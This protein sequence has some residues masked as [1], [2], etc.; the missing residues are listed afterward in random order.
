MAV[1]MAEPANLTSIV[2]RVARLRERVARAAAAVGRS[3]EEI[4]V[5]AVTKGRSLDEIAEARVAGLS[6]F[7]E[8]Y[9]QEARAKRSAALEGAV[10]HFLGRVQRNKL[11][12][13]CASF[14]WLHGVD[15]PALVE[16][17]ARLSD[18]GETLPKLLV[19][20]RFVPGEERPGIS[21][22][23][24]DRFIEEIV[25][26]RQIPVVGLMTMAPPGSSDEARSI[27]RRLRALAERL[28]ARRL[29]GVTMADL[30]MGMSDDFEA[31]I[32]EGATMIRIGRGVFGPYPPNS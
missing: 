13:I 12:R 4:G 31:A 6:H 25:V 3:P 16:A 11:Q 27:F 17:L 5:I 22:D 18:R 29:P 15:R 23:R 2:G 1:R 20:V 28:A 10:W 8:N 24:L 19:E 9:F 14:A 21:P 26:P 30:S 7:G 32:Q